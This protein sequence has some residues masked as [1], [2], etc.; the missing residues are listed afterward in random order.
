MEGVPCGWVSRGETFSNVDPVGSEGFL[1]IDPKYL[2]PMSSFSGSFSSPGCCGSSFIDCEAKRLAS[3][4]RRF[5]VLLRSRASE[6]AVRLLFLMIVPTAPK[7][8]LRESMPGC[9]TFSKI[10][11]SSSVPLE[12]LSASVSSHT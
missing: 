10:T 4:P 12:S 5:R 6:S 9:S 8:P 3:L 2:R 7:V 1:V 11:S